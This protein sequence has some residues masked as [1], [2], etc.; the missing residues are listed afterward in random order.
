M[1]NGSTRISKQNK[2]SKVKRIILITLV[3]NS[4]EKTLVAVS[5]RD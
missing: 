2:K 1:S 5:E 4:T 3:K